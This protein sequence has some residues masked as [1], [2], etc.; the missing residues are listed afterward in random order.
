MV[1]E[2]AFSQKPVPAIIT[3]SPTSPERRPRWTA[4]L[5]EQQA[6]RSVVNP[7]TT[8][9]NDT[10]SLLTSLGSNFYFFAARVKDGR[11]SAQ[12]TSVMEPALCTV[13]DTT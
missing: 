13:T 8:S 1:T 2:A 10:S 3:A 11:G 6:E 7:E 5:G 9:L 4:I 12:P